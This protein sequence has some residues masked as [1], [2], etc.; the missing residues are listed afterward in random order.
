VCVC[1]V[2]VLLTPLQKHTRTCTHTHAWQ[3]VLAWQVDPSFQNMIR[4]KVIFN[5]MTPE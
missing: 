4:N 3:A 2:S 1:E 5:S